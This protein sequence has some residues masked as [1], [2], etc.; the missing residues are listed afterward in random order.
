[1]NVYID[2]DRTLFD[3]D[4][5]LK[6]FYNIIDKYQISKDVFKT[7]QIQCKRDGFNPY[8]ILDNVSREYAFD[9]EIYHDID[10]LLSKTQKYL[11][12]D[13]IPFLNYL[14]SCNYK[15][16]ILTK[17]N[18]EYQKQKILNAKIEDYYNE[19]I[20]TMKH[21]G[22]LNI[23]YSNSI[24]IDDNPLEIASI[25]RKRPKRIIRIKRVNSKYS[26]AEDLKD[27]DLVSTLSEIVENK[28][29]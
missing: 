21:K 4:Q 10:S 20:V 27:I 22:K 18:I 1:M 28:L 26:N 2:F 12:I 25:L 17:G 11:Y 19:L 5:F 13:A 23:D 29:I 8:T 3:C 14:K 16:I 6:D 9:I 15:I 7:C 24:F